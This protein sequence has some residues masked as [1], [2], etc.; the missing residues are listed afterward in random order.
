[1]AVIRFSLQIASK[2]RV[3]T[4]RLHGMFGEGGTLNCK[5]L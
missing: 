2:E 1:V 3:M 5:S 4:L